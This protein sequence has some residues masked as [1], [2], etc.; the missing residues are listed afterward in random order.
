MFLSHEVEY[1][2][3]IPQAMNY[4]D[5]MYVENKICFSFNSLNNSEMSKTLRRV[6]SE[7]EMKNVHFV[8]KKH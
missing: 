3:R 4:I 8:V 5:L 6:I 7:G 1:A 2:F